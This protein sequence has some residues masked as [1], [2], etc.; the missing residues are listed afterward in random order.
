[1]SAAG[2]RQ[3]ECRKAQPEGSPVSAVR[4]RQARRAAPGPAPGGQRGVVL[5]IALVALIFLMIGGAALFRSVQNSTDMAGNVAFKRELAN[6]AER[7]LAQVLRRFNESAIT[8]DTTQPEQNYSAQ[9]LPSGAVGVPDLLL[10]DVAFDAAGMRAEDIV[11]AEAGVTVRYLIDRQ[12][13]APGIF[14]AARCTL[15]E[16]QL[17]DKGGTAWQRKPAGGSGAVYRVSIRVTGPR[18]TQSFFQ[19]TLA[20]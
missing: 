13:T 18:Q 3:D 17:R 5:I 10:N 12:C 15:V 11:D 19:S 2:R 9:L 7:A 20:F 8:T 1:M 14:D 16:E 4:M 6:H